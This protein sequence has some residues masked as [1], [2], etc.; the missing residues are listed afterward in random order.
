[1]ATPH[2]KPVKFPLGRLVQGNLYHGSDKDRKGIPRVYKTGQNAGQ[3]LT[4]FFFAIAIAKNGTTDFK[5]TTWGAQMA[6]I[7]AACWPQGQHQR[8]TFAWKVVDG[9]STIP[10]EGGTIPANC[11]GFPGHWIVKFSGTFAPKTATAVNGAAATWLNTPDA[12][13]VGD[14]VEVSAQVDGNNPS[15]SPG[16]YLNYEA[17]CL[18]AV[19]APIIVSRDVA[20][21]GF[22]AE[23][24]PANLVTSTEGAAP[25]GSPAPPPAAPKAPAPPL[26]PQATGKD[27]RI[28]DL[29][30]D[31]GAKTLEDCLAWEGWTLP[32]LQAQGFAV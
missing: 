26:P 24:L 29:A 8:P 21:M 5:Q 2:V 7:A 13:K 28:T 32:L 18:R 27:P 31:A 3:P 17:V 16:L 9:D 22:G 19:G 12:I 25:A 23:P 11:E 14:Y 15:E 20:E 4:L 6:A 30:R 10:N 1:M